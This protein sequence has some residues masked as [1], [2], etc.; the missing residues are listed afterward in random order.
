MDTVL[1]AE[2]LRGG[3]KCLHRRNIDELPDGAFVA[4]D[5][6]TF[7][8][9]GDTLL[10]WTPDGYDAGEA[11][12]GCAVPRCMTYTR[13]RPASRSVATLCG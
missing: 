10:H 9:R 11:L 8:V 2:R 3:V 13:L 1:H 6:A 5:G 4:F 7:A 12:G